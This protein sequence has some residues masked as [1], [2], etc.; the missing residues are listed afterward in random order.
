MA[1][2]SAVVVATELRSCDLSSYEKQR[3]QNIARNKAIL[4]S[5][6]LGP[7]GFDLLPVFNKPPR[8]QKKRKRRDEEEKGNVD[9]CDG[10][11]QKPEQ[12]KEGPSPKEGLRRSA[13]L[14]NKPPERVETYE[15]PGDRPKKKAKK[16][17]TSSIARPSKRKSKS[18]RENHYGPT[19]GIEIGTIWKMRMDCGR[20]GVHR[21]TVAGIHGGKDGA[22]SI[23]LSGGYEDD[24]DLGTSFTY[25]GEGGRDLKG[26]KNNP[27]NL[28]TA[29][30]SKDQTLTRGNLAL[31]TSY[32]TGNPVRVIRGYKLNSPYAPEEGYRY[33]GIYYVRKYWK[34]VGLSGFSVWKFALVRGDNQPPP[35]W[36]YEKQV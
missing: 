2:Q 4:E 13:R 10:H 18:G 34:D 15:E 27:K 6:G 14:Q 33:D 25:T 23:A 9:T 30:Q 3:A 35:P 5:L 19:D 26:T 32:E 31:A 24:V 1:Q 28:R 7:G 12:S 16:H 36:T 8:S 21:P 17:K 22:Y 11:Q 29:P 20:D